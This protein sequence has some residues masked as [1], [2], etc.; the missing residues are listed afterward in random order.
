MLAAATA[1]E[2]RPMLKSAAISGSLIN[3]DM[4][5]SLSRDRLQNGASSLQHNGLTARSDSGYRSRD[6]SRRELA[7]VS[8]TVGLSGAIGGDRGS[9]PAKLGPRG[10]Q[11]QRRTIFRDRFVAL[12]P[13]RQH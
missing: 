2:C 4:N 6:S 7:P 8:V 9:R 3:R 11:L 13:S 1:A 10:G 5:L 12:A